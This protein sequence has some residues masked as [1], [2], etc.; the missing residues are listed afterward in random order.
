MTEEDEEGHDPD[1][2]SWL[3]HAVGYLCCLSVWVVVAL[4][5][6]CRWVLEEVRATACLHST[7]SLIRCLPN[8]LSPMPGAMNP[9]WGMAFVSLLLLVLTS[10]SGLQKWCQ[11]QLERTHRNEHGVNDNYDCLQDLVPPPALFKPVMSVSESAQPVDPE[12]TESSCTVHTAYSWNSM[13]MWARHHGDSVL[14]SRECLSK[15]GQE[16]EMAEHVNSRSRSRCGW[17]RWG[18]PSPGVNV[19]IGSVAVLSIFVL[20]LY[21]SVNILLI[22]SIETLLELC[23]TS[24]VSSAAL[25]SHSATSKTGL[26]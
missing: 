15:G 2:D 18:F 4:H 19:M 22:R 20:P 3:S 25:V 16:L 24:L 12:K 26:V 8:A 23:V 6:S 17:R 10:S 5:V 14:L 9:F 21:L 11:T 13:Q 1:K 7:K